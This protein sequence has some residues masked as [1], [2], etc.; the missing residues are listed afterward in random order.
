MKQL[1]YISHCVPYPPDKGERIRAYHELRA[2]SADFEITLVCLARGRRRPE[3]SVVDHLQRFCRRV[4]IIPA[5]GAAGL[6]RGALSLAAGRSV[7]EGYFTLPAARNL[8]ARLAPPGG[9]D[10]AMGYCSATLDL[11]LSAAAGARILDVVDADSLK[12]A[13]YARQSRWPLSRLYAREAAAVRALEARA[14]QRCNAVFYVSEAEAQAAPAGDRVHAVANGVD[15]EYFNLHHDASRSAQTVVFL[16]SMDYRPNIEAACW[17]AR[18]V[19]GPLRERH[20]ELEFW[21]V[22]RRPARAV[23]RLARQAGVHVTGTVPDVRPY[24]ARSRLAVAPLMIARGVQNKVLEALVMQRPVVASPAA[25]EGLDLDDCPGAVRADGPQQW[26]EAVEALLGDP[27]RCGRLGRQSRRLIV[28]R[29]SWRHC[30]KPLVTLCRDLSEARPVDRAAET[31]EIQ[32]RTILCFASG[33]DAPPTSKHHVMHELA[34]RNTVLWVCYHGS[35]TPTIA[36]HDLKHLAGRL[37]NVFSGVRQVREN[38]H[39]LTPLV[40]PLPG[41]AAA[42]AINRRLLKWQINRALARLRCGPLQIWSF[43]PDVAYLVEGFDAERVLYYC[44]DDFASFSGYDSNL[45]LSQERA[46]CHR[47]DLVVATSQALYDAKKSLA[48]DTLLVPHGVDWE[49]FAKA[50]SESSRAVP[51]D[52]A[53]IPSPRVGFFGLIRDWVDLDLIAAVAR[54]RR[55]WHFV[56]LGD[57]AVDLTP[58]QALPNVHF[59]GPRPYGAL[60][61]YCRAMNAAMVPFKLNALTAAVN[62][63]K[64]REYL[65]AGLGV[66]STPLPEVQA[67]GDLVEIAAGPEAFEAAVERLLSCDAGHRLRRSQSMS[68]QTWQQKVQQISR[69]LMGGA[70]PIEG[71]S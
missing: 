3:P 26:I 62:P 37:R 30:L 43:C 5:G 31:A 6:L 68:D 2:L 51:A 21:I 38:L 27:A 65:S 20:R 56:F 40:V 52:I 47:A 42:K 18:H 48:H 46:L 16:G 41:S 59:L 45:M 53:A 1:L 14:A 35:R 25:L 67:L 23:R 69:R 71:R 50:L 22:G 66:V 70:A 33:Y 17:Y 12:W 9:F 13:A 8:I 49:H 29:Y 34:R 60:P 54:R 63:I 19:H 4:E 32:G 36:G 28:Q 57:S 58:L 24:V 44:V 64:L 11:V 61:D 7:S 55:Q 39:V 15:L 10:L